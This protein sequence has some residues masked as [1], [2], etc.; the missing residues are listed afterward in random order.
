TRASPWILLEQEVHGAD[1]QGQVVRRGE[2]LR[3]HLR[4]RR[5]GRLPPRQRAAHGHDHDQGRH[6][7]RLRDRR[8]PPRRPGALRG[9]RRHRT[10]R[11]LQHPPARPE[12]GRGHGRHRRGRHQAARRRL[13]RTAPRS[14]PGEGP[15][16]QGRPG[17]PPRRRRPG[18]LTMPPRTKTDSVL[19][20]AVE[21]ARRELLEAT[22]GEGVGEHVGFTLDAER[23]GTHWFE[24][25]RPGYGGWHWGV[26]VARAPRAKTA[27]VCESQL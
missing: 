1:W 23:L 14:L 7:R 6:P 10:E 17:P 13:L 3:L 2:G 4:R 18:G 5:R 27:T 24:A 20:A 16:R 26:T 12:A 21:P 15:G 9:D 8:G 25:T 11:L 19:A 22:Q